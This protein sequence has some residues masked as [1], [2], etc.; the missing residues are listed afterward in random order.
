MEPNW[1]LLVIYFKIFKANACMATVPFYLREFL[2]ILVPFHRQ[3]KSVF[4]FY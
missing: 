4:F 2:V 1:V 3:T